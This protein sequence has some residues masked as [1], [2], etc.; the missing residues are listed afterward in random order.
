VVADA[1][2]A[3]ATA[4]RPRTRYP[5]GANARLA[6]GLRTVLPDRAYDATISRLTTGRGR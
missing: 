5:V 6:I 1:V 3:A 2:V 4:R